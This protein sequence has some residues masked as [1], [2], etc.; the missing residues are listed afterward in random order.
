MDF[1]PGDIQLLHNHHQI[2]HS[3][4]DFENWPEGTKTKVPLEAE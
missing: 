1:R 2:L 3:R 4:G